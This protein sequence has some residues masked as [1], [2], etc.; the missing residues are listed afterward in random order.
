M[1]VADPAARKRLAKRVMVELRV[2]ARAGNGADVRHDRDR[3]ASKEI[4]ELVQRPG[5]MPDG[6]EA[7]ASPVSR[8]S[9]R[10]WRMSRC[11]EAGHRRALRS[12]P[13][14]DPGLVEHQAPRTGR[15]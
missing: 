9:H 3:E 1:D 6:V 7:N 10:R 15:C 8:I 12:R 14:K 5:G 11:L 4:D 13:K 2:V